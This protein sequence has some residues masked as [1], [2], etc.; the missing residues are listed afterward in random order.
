MRTPGKT[1]VPDD[2][3]NRAGGSFPSCPIRRDRSGPCNCD[4]RCKRQGTAVFRAPV[5]PSAAG[6]GA[7]ATRVPCGF[8]LSPSLSVNNLKVL[9]SAAICRKL[10]KYQEMRQ[11]DKF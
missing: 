11:T 2:D 3:P 8:G 1:E 10:K 6:Q 4:E 5:V 7:V 9:G